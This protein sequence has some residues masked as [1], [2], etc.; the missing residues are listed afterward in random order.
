LLRANQ[1]LAIE[2]ENRSIG[3]IDDGQLGNVAAM[4]D[5]CDTEELLFQRLAEGGPAR[6][7]G[8]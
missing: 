2:Q 5:F 7:P 6:A 4:A 8:R 3:A 1:F